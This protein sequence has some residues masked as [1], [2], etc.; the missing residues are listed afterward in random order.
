MDNPKTKALR[1][2]IAKA[3]KKKRMSRY[4]VAEITGLRQST[5][6]TALNSSGGMMYETAETIREAVEQWEAE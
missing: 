2:R 1:D 4:R 3:M 5:V 6:E